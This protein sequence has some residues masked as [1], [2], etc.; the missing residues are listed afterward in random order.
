[1]R[2][3]NNSVF[4][5]Y[6][7]SLNELQTRVFN[8]QMKIATGKD[9]NSLSDNPAGVV[10][11]KQYEELISRNTQYSDNI[12]NSL[13]DLK[14][15]N[16]ALENVAT[17]LQNI[18]QLGIDSFQAGN[19]GNLPALANELKGFLSDVVKSMNSDFN[20]KLLFAGTKTNK[21]S[22]INDNPGTNGNPFEIV[23]GTSSSANP[24][25]LQVFFRGNTSDNI[26]HTDK[27]TSESINVKANDMFGST[28]TQVFESAINM[29]NTLMYNSDGTQRTDTNLLSADDRTKLS[30]LQKEINSFY[31]SV[32]NTLGK[33]GSKMN[34]LQAE[35][36]QF[37]NEKIRLDANKSQIEDVDLASATINLTKD[38]TAMQYSLQIG[39]K[40]MSNT[41]FDFIK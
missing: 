6:Q 32:N 2:I 28:G 38:Q 19:T 11:V 29:Y 21:Q 34:R 35:K 37:E 39:S 26:I 5:S 15:T 22:I 18:N 24:S 8:N 3:T 7:N 10:K 13:D 36:D 4:N 16:D 12:S 41:L 14:A 31:T 20:G 9:I 25:G 23:Q 27:E 1:M 33:V 30:T 40:L 17:N